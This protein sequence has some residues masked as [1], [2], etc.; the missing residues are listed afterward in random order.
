[1]NLSETS[2]GL[3]LIYLTS[4]S[5]L[6]NPTPEEKKVFSLGI[7]DGKLYRVTLGLNL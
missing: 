7:I 2:H 5:H 4:F 3:N 6:S 1:M